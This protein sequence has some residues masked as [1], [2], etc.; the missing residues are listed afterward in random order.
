MNHAAFRMID[1]NLNRAREAIRAAMSGPRPAVVQAYDA[2]TGKHLWRFWTI[3]GPGEKGHETWTGD[4]WK[5]GGGATWM[6][7]NPLPHCTLRSTAA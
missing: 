6:T 7:G 2:E 1:A 5:S 3:P 4:S